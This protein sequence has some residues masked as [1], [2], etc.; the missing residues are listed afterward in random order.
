MVNQKSHILHDMLNIPNTSNNIPIKRIRNNIT[1]DDDIISEL[2]E[3]AA[4]ETMDDNQI[5]Q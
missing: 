2:M 5:N 4:K 1:E 3:T